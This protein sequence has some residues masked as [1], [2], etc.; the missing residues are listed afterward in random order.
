MC[1]SDLVR[2]DLAASEAA[3]FLSGLPRRGLWDDA[4]RMAVYGPEG[5]LLGTA[6]AQG[7][8]LIPMRLL[9]TQEISQIQTQ[10]ADTH[11]IFYSDESV[12]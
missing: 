3:R 9:N 11:S 8:Q 2:V 4:Q 1:S 7:G 6:R 5:V 10:Q 12:S